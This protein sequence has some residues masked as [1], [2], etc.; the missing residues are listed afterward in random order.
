MK[1]YNLW[2]RLTFKPEK[3]RN[4]ELLEFIRALYRKYYE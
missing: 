3:D 1:K 4:D 2:Q